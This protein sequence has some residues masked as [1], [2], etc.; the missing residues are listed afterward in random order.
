MAVIER[1]GHPIN[2]FRLWLIRMY[3]K[4]LCVQRVLA[5]PVCEGIASGAMRGVAPGRLGRMRLPP[6]ITSRSNARVK[7]LRAAFTGR[8]SRPGDLV[9]IEGHKAVL[10]A[11]R[12]GLQFDTVALRSDLAAQ[13]PA[14]RLAD[15]RAREVLVLDEAVMRSVAD[16][17]TAPEILAAVA[18]PAERPG[19]QSR[20][21]LLL[22]AIQ[23][24]GNMG[25]LVRSAE[26]FG[27]EQVF[28]TPGCANPW[29]PKALRASAG[30][31]F[32]QPV[33]QEL[34]TT[35]IPRLQAE[36][37]RVLAAVAQEQGAME[38]AS[39]G[40]VAPVA[41][42]IGNEGAGLSAEVLALCDGR[43]FIPCRTESLNAAVAGSVLLYQAT[44]Q[45]T[46][47]PEADAP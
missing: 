34:M 24:P 4:Q 9:G 26:A 38:A 10:E 47:Q 33:R 39:A 30:S 19:P 13:E 21:Y 7:A 11:Q 29:A 27:V 41:L 44:L 6:P 20:V 14:G 43:V 8:A 42:V 5:L 2:M 12:A 16:T 23:D 45:R 35:A 31:I 1:T 17:V 40:L 3:A 28:I 37:V 18:I 25:T 36:G 15:L 32:R 22:E 46:V